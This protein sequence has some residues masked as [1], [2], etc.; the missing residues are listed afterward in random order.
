M[1][2][3]I[4]PAILGLALFALATAAHAMLPIQHWQTA[5]GARVLFVENH[6]MP[7]IDFKVDFAAGSSAD[8]PAKSGLAG[9]TRHMMALGAGGLSEDQISGKLADIGAEMGGDFDRD[10]AGFSLRTL[11]SEKNKAIDIF[12]RIL[13]APQFDEKI[14]DREKARS[15]AEIRD[16]ETHPEHIAEETFSKLLYGDHPYALRPEG[17]IDTI[18]SLSRQDISGFYKAHYTAGREVIAIVGDITRSD[19]QAIAT[20]LSEGLS[21]DSPLPALPPVADPATA[22]VKMI[23]YPSSQSHILLG[24]PGVRRDDPDYF[25]LFVGNYVLGGGGFESRLLNE[26]R[27]KRGLAYS[28]YSYFYPL[29]ARGPFQVGLQT[30]KDQTREALAIVRKTIDNFIKNGPTSQ[31]LVAAKENLIGGFPLRIDSNRKIVEYL[32][33][34][35]FYRLPL[36]YLDDFTMKVESVTVPEIKDAFSRRV[37]PANMVTVVVGAPGD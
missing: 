25:P 34:I 35:G 19:A 5:S 31:E 36:T 8:T 15:V 26:V 33:M 29:E 10:I 28:V 27:E 6:D 18:K 22:E 11:S 1:E 17:T 24:Y 3:K 21:P 20:R 12:A 7:M 30:R 23:P 14:L 37:K 2:N 4:I 9:M 16:A 13:E 32:G